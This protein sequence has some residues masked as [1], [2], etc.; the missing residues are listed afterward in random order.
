MG[1]GI[2]AVEDILGLGEGK[3]NKVRNCI[4]ISV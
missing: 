4:F 2:I 1:A 3:Q